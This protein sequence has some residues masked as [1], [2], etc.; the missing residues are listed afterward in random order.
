MEPEYWGGN[1][2]STFIRDD[3]LSQTAIDMFFT[4]PGDKETYDRLWLE[5]LIRFNE[6]LPYL[7]LYANTY[8]DFY[9]PNLKNYNT[10]ALWD[11]RHAILYAHME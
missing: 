7:P 11:F 6:I 8:F 3:V 4:T 10:D 9:T 5:N 2:N 1:F